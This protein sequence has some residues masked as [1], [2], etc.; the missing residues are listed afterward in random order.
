MF[1]REHVRMLRLRRASRTRAVVSR[2][3]SPLRVWSVVRT[4]SA[5]V[6]IRWSE[7]RVRIMVR[8]RLDPDALALVVTYRPARWRD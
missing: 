6:P 1:A 2:V 3:G 8:F 4:L 5:T 7:V